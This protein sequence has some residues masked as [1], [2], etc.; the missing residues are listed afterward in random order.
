MTHRSTDY[1]TFQRVLFCP[2]VN[3]IN[4]SSEMM[5]HSSTKPQKLSV[6]SPDYH[7]IYL[8]TRTNSERITGA[9]QN[10]KTILIYLLYWTL[11]FLTFML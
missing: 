4:L 8:T 1:V 3:V 2:I 10:R 6:I 7:L 11:E 5:S 9:S